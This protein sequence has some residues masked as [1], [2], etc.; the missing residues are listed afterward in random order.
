M[1]IKW[2]EKVLAFFRDFTLTIIVMIVTTISGALFRYMGFTESNIVMIYILGVVVAARYTNAY[3]WG[4]M[5]SVLGVAMFNYFFTEPYFTFSAHSR[6]YPITFTTMLT[7]AL[8]TSALTAKIKQEAKDSKEKERYAEQLYKVNQRLLMARNF[9]EIKT[10]IAVSLADLLGKSVVLYTVNIDNRLES[11]LVY[12]VGEQHA[13]SRFINSDETVCA[14]YAVETQKKVISEKSKL[15][16]IPIIGKEKVLGVAAIEY[17]II[18]EM[19]KEL[20]NL[21]DATVVQA[22][23]VLERE[24]IMIKQKNSEITVQSERLKNNMLRAISHDIR[25]PLTGIVGSAS[26]LL[27]HP[28][29]VNAAKKHALLTGIYEDAMWLIH[30]VE[31]ILNITRIDDG[32]L[33]IH[34]TMELAEEIIESVMIQINKRTYVQTIKINIEETMLFVPMDANLIV[35]VL[36][37]LVDNA[38]KYTP[39]NATIMINAFKEE[40]NCVFEVSDNG[41]GIA[42]KDLPYIFDKFYRASLG[43]IEQRSGMGLGLAICQSIIDVH[44]GQIKA[45]NSPNGGAV[46]RFTLPIEEGEVYGK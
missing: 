20:K 34:K 3:Q 46:F 19:T 15:C 10:V 11:P 41:V 1:K 40:T 37:N 45:Y 43:N 31:N 28:G 25:T 27:N 2:A 22:A 14:N 42:E 36:Y 12:Q 8:I 32:R 30:S 44:G 13:V 23:L 26:T 9:E 38:L 16:Y 21:M 35:H 33:T 17:L 4:I 6:E 18:E 5:A 39:A 29:R 7:V 24:E